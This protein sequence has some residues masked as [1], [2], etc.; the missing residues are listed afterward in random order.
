MD[1]TPRLLELLEQ[2]RVAVVEGKLADAERF[3]IE[4]KNLINFLNPNPPKK[5]R[6]AGW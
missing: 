3:M 6:G 4:A 5:L 2:V 1:L